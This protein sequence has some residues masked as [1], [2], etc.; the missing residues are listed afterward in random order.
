MESV[1]GA[2]LAI[3]DASVTMAAIA[4]APPATK[5]RLRIVDNSCMSGLL[6]LGDVG[7]SVAEVCHYLVQ[8]ETSSCATNL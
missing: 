5:T 1:M 2:A 8:T 3:I 4:A 7:C 6:L